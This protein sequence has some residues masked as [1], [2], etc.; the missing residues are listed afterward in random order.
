[1]TDHLSTNLTAHAVL[2]D[3]DHWVEAEARPFF[4]V[5]AYQARINAVVGTNAEG[6]DIIRLRWAPEVET[7]FFGQPQRRYWLRRQKNG[8][9]GWLYTSPPR[10]VFE[11]RQERAQYYGAW[12]R[13]RFSIADPEAAPPTCEDCAFSAPIE[14][15][16]QA[17]G[18][19]FC[20]SCG[21]QGI[22][23]AKALDK[24]EPP[25]EYFTFAHLCAEHDPAD[26]ESGFPAC[27][28]RLWRESRGRCWGY[29]R[30]PN[31]GDIELLRQAVRQRD[32]EKFVSPYR[33]LTEEQ[34][35]DIERVAAEQVEREEIEIQELEREITEEHVRLHGWRLTETDPGVLKHGRMHDLGRKAE[36]AFRQHESGLY[37][38][39]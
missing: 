25:D 5:S 37:L 1:M 14:K 26:P 6:A 29:Y 32:A 18:R 35:L 12:E 16:L 15:F 17:E 20:P 10:W 34:L 13:T 38:P 33:P 11:Q 8:D 36:P 30:L 27:C 39:E 22:T 21:G 2:D 7:P 4:D 23:T 19:Y 24:G 31:D 9:D 3:P 28:E